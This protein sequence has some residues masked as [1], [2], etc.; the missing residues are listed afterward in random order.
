MAFEIKFEGDLGADLTRFGENIERH[1]IRSAAFAGAKVLSAESKALAPVYD[2][3]PR[4]LKSGNML[5]PGLLRDSIYHAFSEPDSGNGK[6]TYSISWNYKKAKHGHLIENGHW[7]VNV[8]RQGKDG[9]W[10]ATSELLPTPVWV[11]AQSFI[12]R[13]GDN[14]ADK[15]VSAMRDRMRTRLQEVLSTYTVTD[16]FGNSISTERF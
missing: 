15:A 8:L 11:P 1:V 9:R 6:A 4:K 5:Q 3:P 14:A 13:A 12:R 16:D 10:F 2:G 7:R